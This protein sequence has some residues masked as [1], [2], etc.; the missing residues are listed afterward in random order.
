MVAVA[1]DPGLDIGGVGRGDLGLGHQEGRADLAR[2]QRLQP[3]VLLGGVAVHVQDFH[4][5]GVGGVA[6]EHL[7]RPQMGAH[8]LGQGRVVEVGQA[9]AMLARQEHVPQARLARGGLHRLHARGLA[10]R[11]L[12]HLG[13]IF[14]LARDDLFVE[15]TAHAGVPVQGA[16][17]MSEVH[18]VSSFF[19][20]VSDGR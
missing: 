9:G 5:A 3:A 20:R 7:R 4:I 11:V 1:L 15:E 13:E 10:V 17:G 12:A 16:V 19:V 2:H 6:V 18:V 14:G 8:H